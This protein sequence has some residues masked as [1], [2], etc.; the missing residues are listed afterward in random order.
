MSYRG[1]NRRHRVG[2]FRP[3]SVTQHTET[4]LPGLSA[5]EIFT[6]LRPRLLDSRPLL[7]PAHVTEYR[8]A[9]FVPVRDK[10][11]GD[12]VLNEDGSPKMR[13]TKYTQH[14]SRPAVYGRPTFQNAIIEGK[15]I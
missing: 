10:K 2:S 14:V 15:H 4:R 7:V 3:S 9:K 11:T 6:L 5:R 12:V 1:S 8:K 13:N